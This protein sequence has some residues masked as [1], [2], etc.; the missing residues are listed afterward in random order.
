MPNPNAIS[1]FEIPVT[2]IDR[3]QSF[4]ET[5][6]AQTL[7]RQGFPMGGQSYTLAIF[8]AP[9]EGVKGCLQSGADTPRSTTDGTLVYL[10]CSPSIDAALVRAGTLGAT[11]L[12]PK[13]ALPPGMGFIAHIQDPDGNRVGLHA[14]A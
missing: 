7:L 12:K 2:D 5:L 11:L 14:L 3:A 9:D 6:L 13:T 8:T 10:D 4:Y 1:W